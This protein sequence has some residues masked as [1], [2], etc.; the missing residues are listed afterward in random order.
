[1]GEQ[2]TTAADLNGVSYLGVDTSISVL[3]P[4]D[5]LYQYGVRMMTSNYV[6]ILA[7]AFILFKSRSNDRYT[8]GDSIA[9]DSTDCGPLDEP[10]IPQSL[11]NRITPLIPYS[12]RLVAER[13]SRRS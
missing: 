8:I 11:Q 13:H 7:Q 5:C 3:N 9:L 4:F 10:Q 6:V 2:I 1:M 12:L